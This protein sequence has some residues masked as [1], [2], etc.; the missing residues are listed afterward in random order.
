MTSADPGADRAAFIREN[1]RILS[2]PLVPEVQLHL[3]EESVPLW[4]KTEEELGEMNV[5][6]PFWAFAWAGGQA[7]A[8]YI[9]DHSELAE[10]KRVVDLGAGSGLC[11]IAARLAG[12]V[13]VLAADVDPFTPFAIAM[14]SEINNTQISATTKDLL[15]EPP[16]PVDLLLVGDLF[17]E[18]ELSHSVLSWCQ[19][20][21]R[22]GALVL[23]GD[24]KRSFFPVENFEPV[25]EYSVPVTRALEDSEIKRTLVWRMK[26][27]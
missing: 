26:V 5:P 25:A 8:R 7:L 12:A 2:P 14:N 17:Y 19:Q 24:P 23:I 16:P 10:G 27:Q 1:T 21:A 3:A 6:P 18:K 11:A 13:D 9:L 20:A 4:E 22:T 15:V